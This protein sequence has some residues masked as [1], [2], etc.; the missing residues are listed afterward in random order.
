MKINPIDVVGIAIVIAG[1]I[2]CFLVWYSFGKTL[3]GWLL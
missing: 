1:L 2:A 3:L